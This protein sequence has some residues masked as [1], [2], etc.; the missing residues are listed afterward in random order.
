M[1]PPE[2][3][4]IWVPSRPSVGVKRNTEVRPSGTMSTF[5]ATF[6][7]FAKPLSGADTQHSGKDVA[8]CISEHVAHIVQAVSSIADRDRIINSSAYVQTPLSNAN[9]SLHS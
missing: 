6:A 8:C 5:H 3:S 7:Q 9:S 2:S 4:E 1:R